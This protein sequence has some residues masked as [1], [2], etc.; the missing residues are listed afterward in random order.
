MPGSIDKTPGDLAEL[1]TLEFSIAIAILIC[2][3]RESKLRI[4]YALFSN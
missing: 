4:Q 1:E 2:M 3:I